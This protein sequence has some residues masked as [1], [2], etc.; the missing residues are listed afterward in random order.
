MWQDRLLNGW[1]KEL[2]GKCGATYQ[3]VVEECL[4]AEEKGD[5]GEGEALKAF[6]W[7]VVDEL[8]KLRV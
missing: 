3:R 8:E 1:A 2:G 5:W 7:G 4:A 6:V